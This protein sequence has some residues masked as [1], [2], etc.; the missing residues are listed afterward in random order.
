MN[1]N[2]AFEKF[3]KS[4]VAKFTPDTKLTGKQKSQAAYEAAESLSAA[5]IAELEK[6]LEFYKSWWKTCAKRQDSDIL[7]SMI[8][9]LQADCKA[10]AV[11]VLLSHS[12]EDYAINTTDGPQIVNKTG[13]ECTCGVCL[14]AAKYKGA[15]SAEREEGK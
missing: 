14:I 6:D 15:D 4:F 2:E 7:K 12:A 13:K 3:W 11:A 9:E 5:R 1:N 8:I 10:M